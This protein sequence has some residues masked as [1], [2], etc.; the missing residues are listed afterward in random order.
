M[1]GLVYGGPGKRSWTDLP[2]P[3]ISDPRDAIIRVDTVSICGTDL[4]ILGGDVPAVQPG[5]VLGHEAVGTV[6]AIGG[7]V[8]GPAEGDRVLASCISACAICRH[9]REGRPAVPRCLRCRRWRGDDHRLHTTA[10]VVNDARR[11]V[12]PVDVGTPRR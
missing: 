1:K 7:G 3:E 4:H 12:R 9:C 8:S 11:V 2:D 10:D 5:R 6:V